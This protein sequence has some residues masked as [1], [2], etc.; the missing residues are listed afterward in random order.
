MSVTQTTQHRCALA[1][2]V[3]VPSPGIDDA[4]IPPLTPGEA[5]A[6]KHCFLR[7]LAANIGVVVDAGR[8]E[9]VVVFTPR[10]AES[11]LR[12][13]V[14]KDFRLFAQRGETPGEVLSNAVE[15]LLSRGFPA[16]C[17]VNSDSP[18]VPR[19]ILEV[20][21]ESLSRPGDC[22]VLGALDRDGYY[23]IGLKEGHRDLFER[24][25]ST[26]ANIVFHTTARA[27]A[28]GLKLE[29]LPPWYEVREAQ[30]LSRL[31]KELLGPDSL[32]RA[33]TAPYTYRYLAKLTETYGPTLLSPGLP[34]IIK[35]L[36]R[37]G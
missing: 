32:D 14:P 29:M 33:H 1:L 16:V 24:V 6:L 19:S 5:T 4:R 3:Q 23:L 34:P 9:G 12:E 26:T 27:A 11:L 8:A 2:V 37:I 25:T 18:T 17:L 20:A 21:I 22:M 7:D 30:G 35:H 36:P 15:D 13:L 10:R 31:C 28:I